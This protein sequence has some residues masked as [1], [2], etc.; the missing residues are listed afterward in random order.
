MRTEAT[1][2]RSATAS[3][4]IPIRP[5]KIRLRAERKAGELLQT[6]AKSGERAKPSQRSHG[7]TADTPP[8]LSDLEVSKGQS[9]RWQQLADVPDKQFEEALVADK[10]TTAAIIAAANP[11]PRPPPVE[12]DALMLSSFLHHIER[13]YL[14][15]GSTR[16]RRSSTILRCTAGRDGCRVHDQFSAS[17][18]SLL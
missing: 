7:A 12:R 17:S 15:R 3:L 18:P 14:A 16:K 5:L 4:V 13:A 10:P 11:K 6:M 2:S 8:K 1:I 9:S